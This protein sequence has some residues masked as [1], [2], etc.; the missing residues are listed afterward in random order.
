MRRLISKEDNAQPEPTLL[1]ECVRKALNL[2]LAKL[3]AHKVTL[4]ME[5]AEEDPVV[6]ATPIQLEQVVINLVTNAIDAHDTHQAQDKT[7]AIGTSVGRNGASLVVEDNGPG[8]DGNHERIF[9]P[10]FSTKGSLGLGLALVHTFVAGWGGQ[11]R[12][13]E[14]PDYKGA[15]LQV[16]LKR[17]RK[18]AVREHGVAATQGSRQS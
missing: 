8:L 1:N 13:G 11:I 5:L 14:A 15:R 16:D 2:I 17:S 4:R 12:A 7:I 18:T 6:V 10:F 3:A 9:D